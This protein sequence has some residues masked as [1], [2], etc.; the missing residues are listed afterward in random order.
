MSPVRKLPSASHPPIAS[1]AGGTLSRSAFALA[2]EP[3][4]MALTLT[5]R[6]AYDVMLWIAQRGPAAVDGGYTSPVSAILRG[7]GATTKAP[8]RLQRYIEQ[9]VQTT[10]V[11]RPLAASEQGNRL[12]DGFEPA[13]EKVT[14]EA[15]TFPLLA[16]ARLYRRSGEAWVTWY[17]PPSIKEQLVSPGRWAQVE[18]NSIARLSTYTAVALYEICARFKDSPGGRTSRHEPEFWTRVLREGGGIKPREFRKFKNEL[19][20]PAVAEINVETEIEVELIEH[21]EQSTLQ[22]VQFKVARK[23]RAKPG[24]PDAADVSLVMRAATLG[25]RE[26][27]LDALTAKYGALKVTEGLDAMAACIGDPDDAKFINRGVH[28]KAMLAKRFPDGGAAAQLSPAPKVAP[29]RGQLERVEAWKANRQKQIRAEFSALP[30]D[31]KAKWIDQAAP[32]IRQSSVMTPA[33][34]KRIADRDWASPLISRVVLD[35]Y[36]SARHGAGWKEPG[37]MDLVMFTAAADREQ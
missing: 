9:M 15:R 29:R 28:L 6:K 16:E 22:A 14:D 18:L 7:Y 33:L 21:R 20:M 11:W 26:V 31:E 23:A 24:I 19:L 30:D 4:T 8:E 35:V 25:V 5:G 34:R 10:V 32:T 13:A 12:L 3:L 36:A 2:I 37:E 27:D 1:N 17:Y